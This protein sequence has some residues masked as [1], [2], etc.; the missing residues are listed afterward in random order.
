MAKQQFILNVRKSITRERLIV[1]RPE[2]FKDAIKFSRLFKKAGWTARGNPP[3]FK[4]NVFV[5]MVFRNLNNSR[6]RNNNYR[7]NNF[8]RNHFYNQKNFNGNFKNYNVCISFASGQPQ[9]PPQPQ[10]CFKWKKLGH[11]ANAC[12]SEPL[13]MA[14]FCELNERPKFVCVS[15]FN[16]SQ[17]LQAK[18]AS[19]HNVICENSNNFTTES[20][21]AS[22]V[23]SAGKETFKRHTCHCRKFSWSSL[24]QHDSGHEVSCFFN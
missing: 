16:N 12:R 17:V 19:I 21:F 6:T 1:K 24:R 3:P 9:A 4:K 7:L 20:D 11:L 2:K 22:K 14:W 18:T 15:T 13:N 10:T 8:N 5:A 23:F